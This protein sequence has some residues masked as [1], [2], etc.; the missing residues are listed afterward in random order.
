MR[1]AP[2]LAS[3]ALLC[4]PAHAQSSRAAAYLMEREVAEAC[5]GGRGTID[6]AGFIERD[7]TG[8]GRADLIVS[9]EHIAC[10][11]DGAFGPRSGFC[12]AQVCSVHVYVREGALLERRAE[13]LGGG[14]TVGEGA[15]PVISGHGHGGGAWSI[16]WTGRG[17]E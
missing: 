9:H 8:D 17:F 5:G 3:L 11:A 2:M 1:L 7:L 13:V 6:P 12:G 14:V 15:T 16:R 4:A 10:G